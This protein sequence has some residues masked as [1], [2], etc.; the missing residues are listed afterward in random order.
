M[1]RSSL[2]EASVLMISLWIAFAFSYS[3]VIS[4]PQLAKLEGTTRQILL[5]YQQCNLAHWLICLCEAGS[6]CQ[7]RPVGCLAPNSP[8][9]GATPVSGAQL[10]SRTRTLA[11]GRCSPQ[12][13]TG[14]PQ[15]RLARRSIKLRGP[16][17]A[18]CLRRL[19]WPMPKY[20]DLHYLGIQQ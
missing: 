8:S 19:I 4:R 10:R 18:F 17:Q 15:K 13:P 11:A 12:E 3:S 20:L 6:D 9:P 1:S 5:R 7:E 16:S 2:I 14:Y